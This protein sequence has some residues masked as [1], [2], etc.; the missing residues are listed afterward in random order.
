MRSSAGMAVSNLGGRLNASGGVGVGLGRC[1]G[2]VVARTTC[3]FWA[4]GKDVTP[5]LE[6][7]P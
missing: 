2:G 3:R 7:A 4:V 1:A 5:A 6:R